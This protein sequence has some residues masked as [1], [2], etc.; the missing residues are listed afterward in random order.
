M[1]PAISVNKGCHSHQWLQPSK[2]NI[3]A[4]RKLRAENN[5][6]QLA[7]SRLQPFP[8]EGALRKHRMWKHRILIPDS[9]GAYQ[10]NDFSEPRPLHVPKRVCIWAFSHLVMSDSLKP[11]GLQLSRLLCPWD[12]PCKNIG[13]GYH[14]LFQSIFL[15]W[16]SNP[17]FLHLLHCRQILCLWATK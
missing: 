3:W 12:F 8:K 7:S 13:V 10:R 6:C 16:R 17:G 11:H 9:W 4:L 1:F 14:F 15:T 5:I 2:V